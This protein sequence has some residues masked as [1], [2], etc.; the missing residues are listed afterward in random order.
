MPETITAGAV[1]GVV[2]ILSTTGIGGN[3]NNTISNCNIHAATTS[4]NILNVGIYAY[5]AT[6]VGNVANNDNNTITNCNIYD[7]FNASTAT[8]GIDIL[9]GNNA[10]TI[11][12]N[13]FYKSAAITFTYTGGS[14]YKT[15]I[16]DYS[17]QFCAR[18]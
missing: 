1:P 11:T 6:A 17:G 3:D 4:G 9:T 10:Y 5:N 12:N 2:A 15:R 13:S 18:F 8:A 14:N 16:L 7:C